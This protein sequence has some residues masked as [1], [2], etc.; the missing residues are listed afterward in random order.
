MADAA[1]WDGVADALAAAG[2]VSHADLA[3]DASVPAMAERLLS[4]A[5]PACILVGFSMGGYVAREAARIAPG[6]VR[7]LVLVAT[8]A[9]ADTPEQAQRKADAAERVAEGRFSGLSRAAVAA[10]LHPDRAGDAATVA[11]VRAMGVRLGRDAFL[12]QARMARVGDHER[13][14]AIACPT[15]VVAAAEDRLRSLAEAEE[16]RD[17]IPGAVLRVVEGSGHMLPVEAP[18]ALA[19]LILAWLA[20]LP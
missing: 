9:R 15:L 8:S 10:S 5:P 18:D 16:L 2:P 6:R 3:R 12:R 20:T 14:G 7:A 11:R 4:E 1:L 19:R 13:L 17:G